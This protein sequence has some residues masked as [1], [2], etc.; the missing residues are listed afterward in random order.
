MCEGESK[1]TPDG[2]TLEGLSTQP[3]KG[4]ERV[5]SMCTGLLLE[6]DN[7]LADGGGPWPLAHALYAL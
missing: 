4:G 2:V 5:G 7:L 6:A 3:W 1:A